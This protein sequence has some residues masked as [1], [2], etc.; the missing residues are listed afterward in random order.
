MNKIEKCLTRPVMSSCNQVLQN[1]QF[2]FCLENQF[3]PFSRVTVR[4]RA[5]W[6]H[7]MILNWILF[8]S[9][10]ENATHILIRTLQASVCILKEH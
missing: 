6:H 8:I 1:I 4:T 2:F 10:E 9:Q 5:N 7:V 3:L